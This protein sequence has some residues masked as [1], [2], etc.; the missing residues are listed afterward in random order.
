MPIWIN[1]GLI[2]TKDYSA[3]NR[4]SHANWSGQQ[5]DS[6]H[7]VSRWAKA[8]ETVMNVPW[9][10]TTPVRESVPLFVEENR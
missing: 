3:V 4:G 7:L 9:I 8:P 6:V 1:V 5:T 2:P 10:C